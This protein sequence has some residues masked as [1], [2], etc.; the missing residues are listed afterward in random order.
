MRNIAGPLA[1]SATPDR[2]ADFD[3]STKKKQQ[4]N[5]KTTSNGYDYYYGSLPSGDS[6]SYYSYG[7]DGYFSVGASE[8]STDSS[9]SSV[10]GS[11]SEGDYS[12]LSSGFYYSNYENGTTFSRG[13]CSYYSDPNMYMPTAAGQFA[14][15]EGSYSPEHWSS[16][17]QNFDVFSGKAYHYVSNG[18]MSNYGMNNSWTGSLDMSSF[19]SDDFACFNEGNYY[20]EY[21]SSGEYYSN[22]FYSES[23]HQTENTNY[24]DTVTFSSYSY[25]PN[26]GSNVYSYSGNL[27]CSGYNGTGLSYTFSMDPQ[28]WTISYVDLNTQEVSSYPSCAWSQW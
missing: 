3:I 12:S 18:S 17:S 8:F 2:I 27:N 21:G 25:N 28:T 13:I 23:C 9:V 14:V 7:Y 1:M 20:S 4:N 11:A 5:Q 26:T 22:G 15:Y 24:R 10:Y 19:A 16:D 6:L